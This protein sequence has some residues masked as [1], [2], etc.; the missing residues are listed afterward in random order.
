MLATR[1]LT[2]PAAQVLTALLRRDG[3]RQIGV[4]LAAVGVYEL[5]RVAI[6]PNWVTATANAHRIIDLERLL[7]LSW[8]QPVQEF[9]LS[10][11]PGLV[12]AMNVFYFVGHFLLTAIF[13]LWL[14]RRSPSGFRSYRN[15]F[16]LATAISLVIHW[17]FPAAPPR[18]AD[19]GM[20]DTLRLFSGIDI[21]SPSSTG[22]SN[23]VAAVP[24]LHAGYAAGVGAGIVHCTASWWGRALGIVY[25]LAIV[26]TIVVTG[27]HFIFDA[28][29]G[30]A[31]MVVGFA[32]A[33]R[34]AGWKRPAPTGGVGCTA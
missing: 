4:V 11:L 34:L 24:S 12:R 10:D 5:A 28:V 20:L 9:F 7:W 2:P 18:V 30:L 1:P 13:F 26:L 25:P 16:L 29:A 8:E 32:V 14:Y 31:V 23:P 33:H 22:L 6:E 27:N 15:G 21:G 3:V 19:A 17:K